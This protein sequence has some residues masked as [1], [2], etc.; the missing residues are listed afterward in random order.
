MSGTASDEF[1]NAVL[2]GEYVLGVLSDEERRQV[3]A[4]AG[5]DPDLAARIDYWIG[6]LAPLSTG[7]EAVRPRPVLKR[8]LLHTLFGGRQRPRPKAA[9]ALAWWRAAALGFAI[10]ALASIT[11]LVLSIL[12]EPGQPPASYLALLTQTGAPPTLTARIDRQGGTV[13]VETALIDTGGR[14]AELWI[15]PDGG[16]PR[17]LGLIRPAGRTDLTIPQALIRLIDAPAAL[18][19]SLEPPGG[20]PTGQPSGPIIAS[21]QIRVL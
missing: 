20:S 14:T 18:A 15:I 7:I 16:A 19:V 1:G 13:T 4:R 9:A 8:R 11:T 12:Q 2:A 17:S 21:G 3:E 5:E 6:R 10:L